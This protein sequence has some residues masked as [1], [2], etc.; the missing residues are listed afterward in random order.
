MY[1]VDITRDSKNTDMLC[2]KDSM[3]AKNK[4][5]NYIIDYALANCNIYIDRDLLDRNL[6]ME[7]FSL[8]KFLKEEYS[9]VLDN[10]LLIQS[11]PVDKKHCLFLKFINDKSEFPVWYSFNKDGMK[12]AQGVLHFLINDA[13]INKLQDNLLEY[14]QLKV[15]ANKTILETNYPQFN[16]RGKIVSLYNKKGIFLEDLLDNSLSLNQL[17]K[18]NVK[19][20]EI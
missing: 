12:Y 6:N 5:I 16:I 4:T 17:T 13:L 3:D 19:G 14:E 1:V 11:M 10:D 8:K 18:E 20:Y 2:G 15:E 7:A 9:I